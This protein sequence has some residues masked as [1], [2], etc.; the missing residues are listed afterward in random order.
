MIAQSHSWWQLGGSWA[1]LF[2][3]SSN[4]K[5]QNGHT[6][7]TGEQRR[8]LP[9]LGEEAA[10][11]LQPSTQHTSAISSVVQ[12]WEEDQLQQPSTHYPSSAVHLLHWSL[13]ADCWWTVHSA[14]KLADYVSSVCGGTDVRWRSESPTFADPALLLQHC[15]PSASHKYPIWC[16]A[17]CSSLEGSFSF[18]F[19][20]CSNARTDASKRAGIL[21]KSVCCRCCA[22]CTFLSARAVIN[23]AWSPIII[24]M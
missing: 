24:T 15:W 21:D 9:S 16:H 14:H 8:T 11:A 20:S 12:E 17:D 2:A 13:N 23:I 1:Q 22:L 7:R 10:T 19:G 4:N 3:S 6:Q 5:Q 18:S